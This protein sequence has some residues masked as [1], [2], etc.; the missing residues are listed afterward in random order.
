MGIVSQQQH[1]KYPQR[2]FSESSTRIGS[3]PIFVQASFITD[4]DA[5]CI[6]TT[7]MR[8]ELFY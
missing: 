7:G 5:V 3:A 6:V 1:H 8:I 4:T 2:M